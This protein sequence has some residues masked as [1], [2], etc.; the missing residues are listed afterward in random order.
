[1]R[2]YTIRPELGYYVL[3]LEQDGRAVRSHNYSVYSDAVTAG[4]DWIGGA[5]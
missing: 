3:T 4:N 5:L 2:T 1:M